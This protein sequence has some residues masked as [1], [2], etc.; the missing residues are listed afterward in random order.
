MDPRIFILKLKDNI[1]FFFDFK[2]Q[3]AM[4]AFSRR[5]IVI[6]LKRVDHFYICCNFQY[7]SPFFFCKKKKEFS[8]IF[9]VKQKKKK[10]ILKYKQ[11]FYC[12][13]IYDTEQ[14]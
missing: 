11:I 1:F 13:K 2:Y 12:L 10:I 9:I 5:Q 7:R 8:A 6:S 3:I 4:L 14:I